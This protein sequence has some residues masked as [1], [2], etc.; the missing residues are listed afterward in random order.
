VCR[1]H[2]VWRS[3]ERFPNARRDDWG[4]LCGTRFRR[5]FCGIRICQ[6]ER[7]HADAGAACRGSLRGKTIAVLGLTFKPETDDMC[8]S[9]SITIIARLVQDGAL[10][11]VFDPKGM[12]QARSALP[13]AVIYCRDAIDAATGADA[14]VL[15]TE[16]NEFRAL[17]P[18]QLADVMLGRI[19]VDLRNVYEPVAMRQAGFNY[20]GVGRQIR[21]KTAGDAAWTPLDL[22]ARICRTRPRLALRGN[23]A[24]NRCP[25]RFRRSFCRPGGTHWQPELRTVR[26]RF[27]GGWRISIGRWGA[28]KLLQPAMPLADVPETHVGNGWRP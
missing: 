25:T 15:M 5:L 22:G 18:I 19:I 6:I 12:E 17:S 16:W 13:A 14:L 11:P 21:P 9:P 10:L 27:A 2:Y 24:L 4:R 20:Y 28:T 1:T 23:L 7:L 3:I 26:P 8:D